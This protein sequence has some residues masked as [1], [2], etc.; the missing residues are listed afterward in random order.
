[1]DT[2]D[3][4]ATSWTDVTVVAHH[5]PTAMPPTEPR[6]ASKPAGLACN[7]HTPTWTCLCEHCLS[8]NLQHRCTVCNITENWATNKILC[9]KIIPLCMKDMEQTAIDW[10]QATD[11]DC[12]VV[13]EKK[14]SGEKQSTNHNCVIL[15]RW[16]AEAG[17]VYGKL[18]IRSLE[19]QPIFLCVKSPAHVFSVKQT[20]TRLPL[21]I[22]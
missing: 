5:P 2:T 4:Q 21:P 15:S 6:P 1:M 8:T 9:M 16:P 3:H 13:Q 12:A 7:A 22:T 14:K 11:T 19:P 17:K 20:S 18:M 10:L